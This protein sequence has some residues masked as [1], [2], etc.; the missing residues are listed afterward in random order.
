MGGAVAGLAPRPCRQVP[1]SRQYD[2]VQAGEEAKR[3]EK[4]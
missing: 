4:E 2:K 3:K 1:L